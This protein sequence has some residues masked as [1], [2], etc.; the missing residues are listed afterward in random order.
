MDKMKESC[1]ASQSNRESKGTEEI[2]YTIPSKLNA[3]DNRANSNKPF[4]TPA[5]SSFSL[6]NTVYKETT[7]KQQENDLKIL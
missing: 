5:I 7:T 3:Y 2:M 4:K 1:E 6:P